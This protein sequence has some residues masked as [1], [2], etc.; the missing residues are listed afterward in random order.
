MG[1]KI[2]RKNG[3]SQ[4]NMYQKLCLL[5]THYIIKFENRTKDLGIIIP[6]L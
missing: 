3:K 4:I 2:C 5:F 6:A 1:L